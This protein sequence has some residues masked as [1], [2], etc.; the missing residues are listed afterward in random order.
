MKHEQLALFE[1]RSLPPQSMPE[2]FRYAPDLIGADEETRLVAAF[3]DLPFRN[4]SFTASWAS[5]ASSRSASAT[6]TT[7]AAC[8]RPHRYRRFC[9]RCASAPRPSPGWRP[10][11]GS[12][13]CHRI[14][15]RHHDRLASRPPAL[16]RR[17][18]RVAVVAVHVPHAPPQRDVVGPRLRAA[19]APLGLSMRGPSRD[20]WE[21]SIPAVDALRYSVTFRT[22]RDETVARVERRETRE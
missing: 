19:R 20:V 1:P 4:S 7:A 16:W 8:R 13:A 11:P 6:I 15:P 10:T 9:C 3:A 5:A 22:M 2:G 21:H 17:D 18:R 14:P 12:R